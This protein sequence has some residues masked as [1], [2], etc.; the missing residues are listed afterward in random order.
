M[1]GCQLCA[2]DRAYFGAF[3][4]VGKGTVIWHSQKLYELKRSDWRDH[5]IDIAHRKDGSR[6]TRVI[7]CQTG[8]A[9]GGVVGDG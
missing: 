5:L 1:K 9:I 3:E 2:N 8:N 6:L 7:C 4:S